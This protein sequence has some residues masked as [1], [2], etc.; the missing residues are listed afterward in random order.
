MYWVFLILAAV[1]FGF[2]LAY[3]V[4]DLFVSLFCLFL[5]IYN[6]KEHLNIYDDK[7]H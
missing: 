6:D 3:C 5:N 1:L 7:E 4:V 2:F